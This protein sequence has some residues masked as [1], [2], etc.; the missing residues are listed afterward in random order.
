MH[1]IPILPSRAD[2]H[3]TTMDVHGYEAQAN[4]IFSG[5]V[6]PGPDATK[7]WRAQIIK[8]IEN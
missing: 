7:R 6:G 4:L 8:V 5:F 2:R 3:G 1:M